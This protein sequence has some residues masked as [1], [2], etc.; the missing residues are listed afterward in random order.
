M[1]TQEEVAVRERLPDHTKDEE[2]EGFAKWVVI[3]RKAAPEKTE[4]GIILPDTVRARLEPEFV[5]TIIS[6]GEDVVDPKQ[7]RPLK[8]GDRIVYTHCFP[9]KAAKDLDV[10]Y[11]LVH[12]DNIIGRLRKSSDLVPVGEP[13]KQGF[14]QS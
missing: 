1:S 2:L 12:R 14:S 5:G 3:T 13:R 6:L 7:K 8:E 4:G 9:M 11:A 10:V